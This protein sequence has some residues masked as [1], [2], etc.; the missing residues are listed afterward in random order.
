MLITW[1][2]A[3]VVNTFFSESA[4]VARDMVGGNVS[5]TYGEMVFLWLVVMTDD[6][7]TGDH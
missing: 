3:T 6:P 7:M 5:C 4:Y 1:P 2:E